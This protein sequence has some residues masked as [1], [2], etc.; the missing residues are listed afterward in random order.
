[1]Y[2]GLLLDTHWQKLCA[3]IERDELALAPGYATNLERIENRDVVDSL[4]VE[5]C[6]A[7]TSE[8][9]L[10]LMADAGLVAAPVNDYATAIADEH[11]RDREMLQQVTMV[12]GNV[13]EITGPAAKFSRTPTEVR[14]GAPRANQ[15]TDEVLG[16]FFDID[17]LAE[18][19]NQCY[20]L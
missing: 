14:H 16:E 1:V 20:K 3:L 11:V 13:V 4:V 5:W 9:V 8:Q 19:I 10:A 17:E 7:R 18:V 15:H 6:A 2:L 12:D